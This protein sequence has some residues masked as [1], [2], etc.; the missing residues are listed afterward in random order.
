MFLPSDIYA[1]SPLP[2]ALNERVRLP[3]ILACGG[4]E[5]AMKYVV[6]S[7]VGMS[8]WRVSSDRA[9]SSLTLCPPGKTGRHRPPH[10]SAAIMWFSSGGTESVLHYDMYENVNC[11]AD[12]VKRIMFWSPDHR[13]KFHSTKASDACLWMRPSPF[14]PFSALPHRTST[15]SHQFQWIEGEC[16]G[17]N[18]TA[19]SPAEQQ[20]WAE[21]PHTEAWLGP[22]DCIY[23]P[24][25]W[26]HQV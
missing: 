26:Y 4:F 19:S 22:G 12:G 1:V 13:Q 5:E 21:T 20:L 10:I 16:S 14:P 8:H 17:L 18:M 25:M 15:T 23:I 9:V 7:R 24:P 3:S 2:P 11:V 6:L